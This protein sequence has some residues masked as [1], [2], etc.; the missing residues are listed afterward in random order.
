MPSGNVLDT[1]GL[2]IGLI[3]LRTLKSIDKL[4]A[5]ALVTSLML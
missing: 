2:E 4:E 1:N 3:L 5:F